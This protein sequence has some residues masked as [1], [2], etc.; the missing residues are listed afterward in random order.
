MV[1][2]VIRVPG[3]AVDALPFGLT[4]LRMPRD[5]MLEVVLVHVRIHRDALRM[6]RF[7]VLGA[8]ERVRQKNSRMSSGSS[9]LMISISARIVSGVSAG[10]PRMYPAYVI[11]PASFQAS[12]IFRYS[13]IL[14]CRFFTAIK[15]PWLMFSSQIMTRVSPARVEFTIE[16]G[17]RL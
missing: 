13:V 9:R 15:L 12:S 16:F 6:K 10:K 1:R 2:C 8:G 14:F 17:K 4:H 3:G 7:V 11:T 5:H